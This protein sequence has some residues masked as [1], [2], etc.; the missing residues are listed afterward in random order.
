MT[1]GNNVTYDESK[2]AG[3]NMHTINATGDCCAGDRVAF[4]RATFS[5]SFRNARFAGYEMVFAEITAESYGRDKQQHTFTLRLPDGQK[6]KIK[7]RNL[8]RNGVWRAPW[9]DE[10]AR[11]AVLNEKHGRGDAARQARAERLS[12]APL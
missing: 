12:Y 7:G 3:D 1:E 5:G 4:E 11:I 6:M 8:Y 10:S 9:A 2:Y